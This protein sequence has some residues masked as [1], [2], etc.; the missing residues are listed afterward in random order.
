[1]SATAA[2]APAPAPAAES[3]GARL[4]LIVMLGALSAFGPFSID[5]YL[6]SLPTIVDDFGTSAAQIQLTLSACLLGIAAGQLLAGPVS[7]AVGRRR[8]LL[9]GLA[10]YAGTSLAC[11]FA[12]SAPALIGLRFAQG[13][14]GAAGMVIG[15]AIVR[16]RYRGDEA[17]RVF[18][19]LLSIHSCAP[20]IAPLIGSQLLRLTSWRG[21]FVAL[22][23]AGLAGLV[24]VGR[25][26]PETLPPARRQSGGLARTGSVLRELVRDRVFLG[27]AFAC[28]GTYGALFGYIAGSP[29][30]LQELYGLSPVAF[31]AIFALNGGGQLSAS[32]LNARLLGRFRARQM[33]AAGLALGSGSAA[34]LL[35]LALAG[36]PLGVAGVIV[37]LFGIVA[38]LGFVIPNA[39]ALALERHGTVA[40]SASALIGVL[41]LVAGAL[42][43]SAVGLAGT[44]SVL[45]MA[46]AI[47]V[48]SATAAIAAATLTRTQQGCSGLAR[49]QGVDA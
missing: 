9:C 29:F 35:A 44:S 38:C 5:L 48:L 28:G 43:S 1:V 23:A 46:L 32:L 42:A 8:P 37:P 33:L 2:P 41:Q 7:D 40:G 30:A 13:M 27:Y 25:S 21:T 12:P 14:A 39:T 34:L 26:L 36:E 11:A 24:V 4:R 18:S 19:G 31:A 3:R 10:L 6:P 22:A 45:P 49:E 20:L 47:A 15:R 17:A 16:D